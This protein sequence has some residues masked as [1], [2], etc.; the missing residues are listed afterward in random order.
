VIWPVPP[1]FDC[2]SLARGAL[3]LGRSYP[4]SQYAAPHVY[5]RFVPRLAK[6]KGLMVSKA[7]FLKADFSVVIPATII[8]LAFASA[9]IGIA[10]AAEGELASAPTTATIEKGL[11]VDEY[12][13]P[14]KP[15]FTDLTM[16]FTGLIS[17][18]SPACRVKRRFEIGRI[19]TD[20]EYVEMG[21]TTVSGDGHWEFGLSG[22]PPQAMAIVVHVP[23]KRVEAEG[24]AIRCE[25]VTS[26]SVPLDHRDFT[27]C[28]LARAEKR[29]YPLAIRRERQ[30]LHRVLKR[31]DNEAATGFRKTLREYRA[32]RASIF[33]A[34]RK[35]C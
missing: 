29:G 35:R 20:N 25:E 28:L 17:S 21:A 2:D 26:T 24:S 15:G 33:E 6:Q 32:L 13:G 1:R 34:V 3:G 30:G 22:E 27:S 10:E 8:T 23:A 7:R 5:K 14:P 11:L 12:P 4:R 31:G 16:P 18:P 9:S 19:E